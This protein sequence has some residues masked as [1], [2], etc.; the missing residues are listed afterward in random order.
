MAEAIKAHPKNEAWLRIFARVDRNKL[1]AQTAMLH[2]VCRKSY[3]YGHYERHLVIDRKCWKFAELTYEK[4]DN[5]GLHF[6]LGYSFNSA[7]CLQSMTYGCTIPT[8][9]FSSRSCTREARAICPPIKI[10]FRKERSIQP[11]IRQ[12]S[13][14]VLRWCLLI[15][16]SESST[17]DENEV[18][19]M[20]LLWKAGH[21]RPNCRNKDKIPKEKWA[22]NEAR[23]NEHE[24][25]P[26]SFF[27]AQ[28]GNDNACRH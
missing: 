4:F 19:E 1:A 28:D 6:Y 17:D 21:V 14:G 27:C 10:R 8:G 15:L 18:R 3:Y 2:A 11:Y 12:G 13:P 16:M 23:S 26:Q 22:T 7:W 20:L 24:K 25:G 5:Y 9:T